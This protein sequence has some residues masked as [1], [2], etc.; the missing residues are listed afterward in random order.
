LLAAAQE[1]YRIRPDDGYD[2]LDHV[3]PEFAEDTLDDHN[4]DRDQVPVGKH[5]IP[6]SQI[7][8]SPRTVP[9]VV[10]VHSRDTRNI[11]GQPWLGNYV[12][13]A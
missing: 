4:E 1:R 7:A 2:D 12:A 9:F 13:K 6:F 5:A 3:G 11:P 10:K 8:K